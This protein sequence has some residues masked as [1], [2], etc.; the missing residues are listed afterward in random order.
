MVSASSFSTGRLRPIHLNAV[1]IFS[2][3]VKVNRAGF[4][5]GKILDLKVASLPP[6][7]TRTKREPFKLSGSRGKKTFHGHRTEHRRAK[8]RAHD[9][10]GD[11]ERDHDFPE[12]DKKAHKK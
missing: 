2:R 5:F 12:K 6:C 4:F 3:H 10:D 8:K 7:P 1:E 9:D 11:D